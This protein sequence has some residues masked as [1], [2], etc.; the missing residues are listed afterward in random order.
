MVCEICS[1]FMTLRR[2]Y[3][4]QVYARI[5]ADIK[6]ER[7][8]VQNNK[9]KQRYLSDPEFRKKR[10][11]SS[12]EYYRKKKEAAKSPQSETSAPGIEPGLA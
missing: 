3:L 7:S 8:M 2:E 12:Q 1:D 10:I 5:P 4:K 9:T 6:K 11:E